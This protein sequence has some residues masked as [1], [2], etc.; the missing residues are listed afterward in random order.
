MKKLTNFSRVK[1]NKILIA[2][3]LEIVTVF[4]Y[5]CSLNGANAAPTTQGTTFKPQYCGLYDDSMGSCLLTAKDTRI[6]YPAVNS[7]ECL[8]VTPLTNNAK[9]TRFK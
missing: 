2:V 1:M 8:S 6:K 7:A 4:F 9:F 3:T 5:S